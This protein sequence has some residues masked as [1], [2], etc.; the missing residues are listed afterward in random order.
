MKGSKMK[1]VS[2]REFQVWLYATGHSQLLIRSNKDSSN[3]TR[4]NLLFKD[5]SHISI[6]I[7][8]NGI[9][10]EISSHNGEIL[11]VDKNF[12]QKTTYDIR[13]SEGFG[14]ICAG[15]FFVNEDDGEFFDRIPFD[16]TIPPGLS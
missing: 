12:T 16:I 14:R 9:S 1:F 8:L 6:P 5:V 13:Y 10:V 4:I 11:T 3:T 2:K 15:S 7:L